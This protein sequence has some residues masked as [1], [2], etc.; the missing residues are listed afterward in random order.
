M[1]SAM[2]GVFDA[3]NANEMLDFNASFSIYTNNYYGSNQDVSITV[4]AY[5]IPKKASFEFT[6]YKI[7]D[8]GSFLFTP[9]LQL[10][11]LMFS[12]KTALTCFI[13]AMKWTNLKRS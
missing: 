1:P 13:Y 9:R 5:S 8:P 3:Q 6:I 4:S 7:K 10:I 11:Q 12:A 2:R